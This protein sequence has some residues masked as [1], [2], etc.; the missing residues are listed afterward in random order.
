MYGDDYQMATNYPLVR[1][2]CQDTGNVFYCRTFNH[3]SMAVASNA[4]VSTNFQVPASLPCCSSFLLEVVANGIPS[5][6]VSVIVQALEATATPTATTCGLSNGTITISGISGGIAPYFVS[7]DGGTLE[8]VTSTSYTFTGVSAGSH[9]V[10]VYDSNTPI[11]CSSELMVSVGTSTAVGYIATP[12][13]TTCGSTNG[14]IAI[15]G[16]SGGT[17]P[18]FASLDGGTLQPVTGTSYTFTGVTSGSHTV[19]VSDSTTPTACS[20]EQMVSVGSS[21]AVGF[22][23][24]PTGTTC[25]LS[26]GTIVISG[27]SGGI[28]PYFA[29]LDGGTLQPVTG[30]SYTFTGVTSGSH[31]VT[32]SDSTTPTA[33]SAEQMVSVGSSTAV[34]FTATPTGTTCGVSNGTIV[35]SGISGGTAPYFA[36][37]DGGTL[38][39]VTGTYTFTGV[40]SGSHTVTVS[41]SAT[42]TAC[43]TEQMVSVGSSIAVGFTATPKGTTCGLSNGTIAITGI[44]GGIAPY[45]VSLDGGGLQPVTGSSYTF[46]GVTSGNHTVSVS[47]STT[48]TACSTEQMVSVGSST[49]VAFTATLKGTTCGLTNGSIII[50]GISG[51]TAPYFISLDGGTLQPVAGTSYTFTGVT[52]G[53]HTVAVSDSTTPTVCSAEQMVSVGSSTAVAFTATP[54][55]TTCGLSNGTIAISG[56]SGGTAT[57]Y[58]S[59]DGG[60]AQPITGTSFTFTGVASGTHSVTVS[61]STTPT[62]C[63]TEQMVSIGTSTAITFPSITS[64]NPT[65]GSSNGSISFSLAGGT[66]PYTATLS[67]GATSKPPITNIPMN[68]TETFSGL[69]ASSSPYVITV[70]DARGCMVSSGSITISGVNQITITVSSTPP[71]CFGEQ[72]DRL[73]LP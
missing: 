30:T 63:S 54:T 26:N 28:A 41:D 21:T 69:A 2:T 32:V 17:A 18:Y 12:T 70:T 50:S 36:S 23:A 51:G 9:T 1:L 27:I 33:C 47:D 13:A 56:I 52:S 55:G 29:S 38:E 25:G 64:T 15:S 68:T 72:M 11:A 4:P 49:A 73:A 31:T 6:P 53:N 57:Y 60:A 62:A 61:D 8:P 37:L 35:I 44:S 42:P 45:F 40:T 20:T 14:T 16:I 5:A 19:T 10:T 24:T 7:L 65:C 71:T 46:T 43:S 22:S 66:A 58:A 39:P 48:P 3:S 34:G 67:G 59:L